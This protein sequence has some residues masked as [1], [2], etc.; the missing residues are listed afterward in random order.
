MGEEPKVI[1]GEAASPVGVGDR[2]SGTPPAFVVAAVVGG[3]LIS[4]CGARP[5]EHAI[6]A[7][8][9]ATAPAGDSLLAYTRAGLAGIEVLDRRTGMRDTLGLGILTSP[10]HVEYARDRWYVSDVVEGRPSVAVL[11][12][13]G[14]LERRQE[15]QTLG[16]TPHQFAVLPDGRLVVE[17]GTQ[18]VAL[19]GDTASTF[20]EFRA[21]TVSGFLIS[22]RGGVLHALPDRHIT[23]YNEFGRIRWRVD[24]PWDETLIVADLEVDSNG[25]FHILAAVPSQETFRV[26]SPTTSTGEIVLWSLASRYPSFTINKFGDLRPDSGAMER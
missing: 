17:A 26:Y 11:T 3:L 9:R 24:W 12:Q 14:R 10:L 22:A 4:A 19:G 25:R 23:L 5:P 8:G 21:G 1:Q 20:V 7:D 18:L 15:L 2:P 16:A 13:E 6:F